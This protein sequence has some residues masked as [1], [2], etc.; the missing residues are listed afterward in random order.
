MTPENRFSFTQERLAKLVCPPSGNPQQDGR[1]MFYDAKVSGLAFR[2][3]EGG[4]RAFYWSRRVGAKVRKVR[5]GAYPELN[6][7]Q[8]RRRALYA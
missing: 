5:I 3:S 2:V 8:A 1:A 7:E 4:A 6:V